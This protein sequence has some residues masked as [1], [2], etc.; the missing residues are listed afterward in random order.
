M[1]YQKT[2]NAG[3][4][5]SLV[6]LNTARH[7]PHLGQKKKGRAYQDQDAFTVRVIERLKANKA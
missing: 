3:K 7:Q 4:R 2:H 6:V 1:S 5:N